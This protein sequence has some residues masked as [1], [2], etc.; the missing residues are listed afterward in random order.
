MFSIIP[1]L[2]APNKP[3]FIFPS[4]PAEICA[5][6]ITHEELYM[7]DSMSFLDHPGGDRIEQGKKYKN[8]TARSLKPG[9]K[10]I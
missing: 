3:V 9:G 7:I 6:L 4:S 10:L 5:I 2:H 1:N 8:N